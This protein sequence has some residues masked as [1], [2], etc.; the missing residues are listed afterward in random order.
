MPADPLKPSRLSV[1]CPD[2][3]MPPGVLCHDRDGNTLVR[4]HHSR[5]SLAHRAAERAQREKEESK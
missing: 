1:R 3:W 2:C 5:Y 4:G